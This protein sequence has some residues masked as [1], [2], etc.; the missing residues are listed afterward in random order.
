MMVVVVDKV[1]NKLKQENKLQNRVCNNKYKHLMDKYKQIYLKIFYNY[2]IYV[3][4]LIKQK[5]YRH[6]YNKFYN[7][8]NMIEILQLYF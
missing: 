1:D 2:I 7:I 3:Y 5:I 4:K 8:I 6:Y